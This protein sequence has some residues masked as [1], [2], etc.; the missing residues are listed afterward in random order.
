MLLVII[1]Y[2]HAAKAQHWLMNYPADHY[3]LKHLPYELPKFLPVL[4]NHW[5]AMLE[6]DIVPVVFYDSAMQSPIAFDDHE[7]FLA[8]VQ[9]EKQLKEREISVNAESAVSQ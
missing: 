9:P 6:P 2:V 4:L 5:Q 3:L 1:S 8:S 7:D